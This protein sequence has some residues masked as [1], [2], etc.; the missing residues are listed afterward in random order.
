MAGWLWRVESRRWVRNLGVAA[1][2]AVVLQGLLGGLTVL[3]LLPKPVSIAH[4]CL[5][6]TFFCITICLALFTSPSWRVSAQSIPDG[7]R[8]RRMALASTV[9]VFIQLILGALV[10]HTESA[11][12]IPD[13]PLSF[14]HILPPM[15]D[16][17]VDPHAPFPSTL[18]EFKTRVLIH[19]SHRAWAVVVFGKI[20]WTTAM[21]LE[22]HPK[23]LDLALPATAMGVLVLTQI[24]L[25]AYVV[26]SEKSVAITS[27]HV[28]VGATILA[29]S[30]LLTLRTWRLVPT[31]R[32]EGTLA[33]TLGA[34]A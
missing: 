21:I 26:W 32:I 10:R 18:G 8:L 15:S 6:Q 33:Q 17:T 12:A 22:R 34:P 9:A 4:A 2:L 13:F 16:L 23:R 1:V 20:L 7:A 31:D 24:A 5:A 27:A 3:F 11:L 25:G 29:T 19:Y 30:L 14:G 28:A